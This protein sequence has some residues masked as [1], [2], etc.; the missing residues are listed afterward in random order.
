[1]SKTRMDAVP[2]VG[3]WW[4]GHTQGGLCPEAMVRLHGAEGERLAALPVA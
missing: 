4:D 1:M 3:L 2:S